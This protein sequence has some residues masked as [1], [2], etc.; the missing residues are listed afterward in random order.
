ML[1]GEVS[2]RNVLYRMTAIALLLIAPV[3]AQDSKRSE[4][5]VVTRAK[6]AVVSS[7]DPALP[8]LT[9]ESFLTYET[10]DHSIDWKNSGCK[11][12]SRSRD[13]SRNRCVTAYSSL[14]D[15][16]V[17]TVTVSVPADESKL[18]RLISVAVIEKGL[19]RP[20][21]LIEVP[22]VAQPYG[23]PGRRP[24]RQPGDLFPLNRVG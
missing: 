15:G 21:R 16:R 13:D 10:G 8:N 19:E 22:A 6:Q 4:K 3:L 1:A 11:N 12:Q 18:P 2:N 7:F 14:T 23:I 9:L 24:E 17:I 5:A 20:I